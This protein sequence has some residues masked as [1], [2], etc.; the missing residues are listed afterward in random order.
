[1]DKACPAFWS[2]KKSLFIF[3]WYPRLLHSCMWT[4]SKE[5]DRRSHWLFCYTQWDRYMS[6]SV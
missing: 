2:N 4:T 1:M 3:A 5:E 6:G